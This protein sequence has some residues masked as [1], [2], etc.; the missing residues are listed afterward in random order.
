MTARVLIVEDH[1]LIAIGLQLALGARGWEV[2]TTSGPTAGSPDVAP[3]ADVLRPL[4]GPEAM[5]LTLKTLAGATRVAS[6]SVDRTSADLQ[7]VY[8]VMVG[9]AQVSFRFRW[10]NNP[11][12]VEDGGPGIADAATALRRGAGSSGLGL[13]IVARVARL[14][15]GGVA[16]DRSDMGGARITM[17]LA[18]PK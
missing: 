17:I 4:I 14:I 11:L 10:Y 13:D 5:A 1:A 15:G 16:I 2:E 7:R 12:V 6:V 18:P 8:Y 3:P 9:G